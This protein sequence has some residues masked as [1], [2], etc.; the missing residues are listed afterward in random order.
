MKLIHCADLHLDSRMES[1]LGKEKAK[2]RRNELL[3]GF[4]RL[5]SYA[6]NNQV[7]G[8]LI[9][10]D[11]FDT[12][13]VSAT[14]KKTVLHLVVN[15]PE[16][17]FFYL[18]GNHDEENSFWEEELP[19]NLK[20]FEDSWKSYEIA[21]GKIVITGLELTK[22][23]A[24]LADVN[25]SL[26]KNK[27][28]IILLH[29]Q[30]A[31]SEGGDGGEVVPLKTL[32]DRGID[33]LAL[34]HIHSFKMQ[35][36]DARGTYCYPGCLEGRGFDECGKHGFV[37]LD[38]DEETGQMQWE[39]VSHAYRQIYE[40][41]VDVSECMNTIEMI[42]AIKGVLQEGAY[43]KESMIKL[44]LAGEIPVE[45]EKDADYIV[46]HFK[47]SYYA[48]KV[49]DET[50]IKVEYERYALDES[51]KGEFVRS[52]MEDDS[53]GEEEKG[54]VIRYGLQALTGEEVQ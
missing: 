12:K 20:L 11:L 42:E 46:T 26:D 9:A 30:E 51:L 23:N 50:K 34:G 37:L 2:E 25:L 33:Y 29:G 31:E 21:D 8:I 36:L 40:V 48:V 24:G 35:Q 1:N 43:S 47:D 28:N 14:T 22:S 54:I 7:E 39:F 10:G 19:D 44:C 52:V 15:H 27:F 17:L 13:R 38:I 3:R 41:A 53:L 6:K 49:S 4:E 45:C 32:R 18:R 16:I 5:V